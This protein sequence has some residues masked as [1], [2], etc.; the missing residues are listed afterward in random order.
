MWPFTND[1]KDS[2]SSPQIL[3]RY[4]RKINAVD[5]KY[6]RQTKIKP[7][8]SSQACIQRRAEESM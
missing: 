1:S 5:I 4:F 2:V 3:T 6:S 7:Q 8:Q